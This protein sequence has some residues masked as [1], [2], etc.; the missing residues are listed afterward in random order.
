MTTLDDFELIALGKMREHG[1]ALTQ[2]QLALILPVKISDEHL[3]L[4][5]RHFSEGALVECEKAINGNE[6]F[7]LTGAGRTAAV[8]MSSA[9]S[10]IEQQY[11]ARLGPYSP[12]DRNHAQTSDKKSVDW[13]KWGTIT[14]VVTLLVTILFFGVS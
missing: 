5:L 4:A 9:L 12:L 11:V 14:A 8:A 13:T 6:Y 2:G 7:I 1:E 10:K 3:A